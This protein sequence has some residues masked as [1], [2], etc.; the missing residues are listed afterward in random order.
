VVTANIWNKG[1]PWQ[2]RAPLLRDGL[3]ALDADV[4]GLQE[5]L[6]LPG[7]P[8][9][10]DELF[11]GTGWNIYYAP[12]W[13]VGGGLTFGNA[14]A[15]PHRLLDPEVIALPTPAG[16]DTRA[17]VFARV[18]APHGP[19]PVFVTH[20]T[21]QAHLGHVRCH[22]VK[23]LAKLVAERAPIDGPPPVVMGDMNAAPDSDEMRYLRGLTGLG[24]DCVYFADC[25][26]LAGDGTPGVTYDRANPYALRSRE[27]SQRIDYVFVRGPDRHLR[28]EP[29]AA[30]LALNTPTGGVWPSDHHAVVADIHAA[31]RPHD[32]Y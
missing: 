24:G 32:P 28:G 21:V 22:Q 6:A 19:M 18:D 23:A 10:A 9:Q 3:V 25:W 15:S 29:I 31:P 12:A 26:L 8:T 17:V 16:L 27:P 4:V 13:H 1:G 5:V 14:I 7:Q 11:A 30:R 20:L 2:Q